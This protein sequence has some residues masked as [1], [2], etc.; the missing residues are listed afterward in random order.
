MAPYDLNIESPADYGSVPAQVEGF[1][2]IRKEL[3]AMEC[4]ARIVA[5][6]WCDRLKDIRSFAEARAADILQIKM[7]DKGAVTNSLDA[8]LLCKEFNVGA[9]LGGSCTETDLSAR[10]SVHVAVASQA[11]MQLAKPGMGVDE[12]LTI[13]GNEQARLL[14]TLRA[15]MNSVFPHV[16]MLECA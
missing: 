7:P 10:V 1:A 4:T 11:A 15:K 14:M 3:R 8:V 16:W 5:D 6:E 13:V 9:Y 2:Q 12:A